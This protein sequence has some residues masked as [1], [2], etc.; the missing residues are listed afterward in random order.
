MLLELVVRQGDDGVIARGHRLFPC[1]VRE[2]GDV[3]LDIRL[4]GND[5]IAFFLEEI[6]KQ[7][8]RALAR[9][10]DVGFEAH[11]EHGDLCAGLHVAADPLHDPF[12]LRVV[13]VPRLGDQ[14][15]D[16]LKFL[17]DEPRVDRDAVPADADARRMD[18]HARMAVGQLDELE[19]VD[20]ETVADFAQLIGIGDVDVAERVLRQLAH[21][22]GQIV[23]QADR[24]L[25]DD[26]L[27]DGLGVLRR[28]GT[29]GA[30]D[31]VI[32]PQLKEHPPRNDALWAVRRH[33]LFRLQAADLG[34][35]LLDEPR[36]AGRR[37]GF[38]H[39]ESARAD[40][41]ADL[42]RRGLDKAHVGHALLLRRLAVGRL[43]G[44]DEY[45]RRFRRR[46]E[47]Q[48]ARR[49]RLG[50]RLL[51]AGFDNVDLALAQYFNGFRLDVEAADLI[52][53]ER[54]RDG[55]GQA[56]VAAAHDLN[57]LHSSS[58]L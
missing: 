52:A 34:D 47:V 39:A 4:T 5:L 56:D 35:D 36:R 6:C 12:G 32:L 51:Q 49:H 10:V 25:G 17:M 33:K 41:A 27:I 37:G 9:V 23:G 40:D 28:L 29:I 1:V 31:A 44:D 8:G 46:G 50:E 3:A 24:A 57:F 53:R 20:A 7:D 18:V 15:R 42:A 22:G 2:D 54:E 45:I 14:R 30:D 55:G 19:D 16:V 43:D 13:D 58:L 11:A 26:L 48:A 38:Q 21:L